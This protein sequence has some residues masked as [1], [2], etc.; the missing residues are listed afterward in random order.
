VFG[1]LSPGHEATR[2]VARH[3]AGV[4]KPEGH[5][6]DARVRQ[7]PGLGCPRPTPPRA[8]SSWLTATSLKVPLVAALSAPLDPFASTV[9]PLEEEPDLR[10]A[11]LFAQLVQLPYPRLDP[12]LSVIASGDPN[13]KLTIPTKLIDFKRHRGL[14]SI[15]WTLLAD[16]RNLGRAEPAHRI[17]GADG[18]IKRLVARH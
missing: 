14:G 1:G 15:R 9:G 17:D 6:L 8:D 11:T 13:L 10:A 4:A 7:A 18:P 5:F 2:Q 3:S 12:P 16:T